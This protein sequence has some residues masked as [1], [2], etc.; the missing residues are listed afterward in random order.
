M[1][2][3]TTTRRARPHAMAGALLALTSAAAV[4]GADGCE[5]LATLPAVFLSTTYVPPTG[6]VISVAS[7]ANLQAALDSAGCGQVVELA[8]GATFTGIFWLNKTCPPTNRIHVRSSGFASLPP[9]GHRVSPASAGSMAKLVSNSPYGEPALAGNLNSSG[10][11]IIGLEI[12]TA[13]VGT[14]YTQYSLVSFGTDPL[15]TE[16]T[17]PAQLPTDF[18]L[19]RVYIH[20]TPGGNV[21]RGILANSRALAVIDSYID[22]IHEVDADSQA[23]CGWSGPGPF[24]IANNHLE[25]AGENV[26]F[27][28]AGTRAASFIPSDLELKHNHV[29]KP[30][31][32][33]GSCVS[34]GGCTGGAPWTVKNLFELKD[35]RRALIEGNVFAQNWAESQT[36]FAIL[37]TVR[38]DGSP[39]QTVEDITFRKNVVH[40]SASGINF[41]VQDDSEP[42]QPSRRIVVRDDLIYNI[43]PNTY[44]GDGRL[45]QVVGG[46][47]RRAFGLDACHNT[48]LHGYAGGTCVVNA[49]EPP[50]AEDVFFRNNLCTLGSYGF[51]GDGVGIGGVAVTTYWINL[52]YAQNLLVGDTFGAAYPAGSLYAPTIGAAGFVDY[53]GGNYRLTPASPGYR[54]GT[55]GRDVGADID[56]IGAATACVISGACGE[57]APPAPTRYYALAACRILDTRTPSRP[58]HAG[59]ERTFPVAGTC[60]VPPE[61]K[62]IALNITAVNPG[63]RGDL[64]LYPAGGSVPAASAINFAPGRTR[65]NNALLRLGAD[66]LS[67]RCDMPPGSLG[68]VHLVVDVYGYFR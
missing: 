19:D 18:T 8:A 40:D 67:A 24:K 65:A 14:S 49:S 55:D 57:D 50:N 41:G 21:R 9:P 62:A 32:W 52:T 35:M 48:M 23:I 63:D 15:G 17:D 2:M 30:L 7:G 27:G 60:G 36:G 3:A 6:S 26:M 43:D 33:K 53:A 54:A 37:F 28:G 64:R 68:T 16:P 38:G 66:G 5:D 13:N 61:A 34:G 58:L 44:G 1:T 47:G 42:S 29:L 4:A 56:A 45:F 20:G 25:A 46:F 39:W 31:S 11:R 59:E 12:T 10:Y 51:F 22:N